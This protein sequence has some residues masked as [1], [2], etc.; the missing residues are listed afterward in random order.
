V[1][2]QTRSSEEQG[3]QLEVQGIQ[4][5]DRSDGID[6]RIEKLVSAIG[7]FIRKTHP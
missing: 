1:L 5:R 4:F 6:L 7:E 3:K 2:E